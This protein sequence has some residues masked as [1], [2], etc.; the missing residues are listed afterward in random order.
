MNI[1]L[2]FASLDCGRECGVR[3]AYRDIRMSVVPGYT[4]VLPFFGRLACG[5]L[6]AMQK[7]S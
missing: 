2:S 5:D 7:V 6:Y 3:A 1:L 4:E